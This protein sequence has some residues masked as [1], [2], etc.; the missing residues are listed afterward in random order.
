VA[1]LTVAEQANETAIAFNATLELGRTY[2]W[3][4]K[5]FDGPLSSEWSPVL[6]FRAPSVRWPTTGEQILAFIES[7]Y[8]AYLEP[9]SSLGER[10]A[11]MAFVRDRM[12]EAGLCG[13]MDLG[14]N[15][16]RGGPE[17]S[18]DFL[19]H[20]ES[21]R[22]EGIDIGHDYDNYDKRLALTWATG[23]YPAYLAYQPAPTCQ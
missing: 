15:L 3:R 16:K 13:G 20:R 7:R 10:Q 1:V 8:A 9:T 19:T 6:S 2:Y 21:G 17:I 14:W 12:I 4:V 5:A 18:L 23:E 22:V 11:N